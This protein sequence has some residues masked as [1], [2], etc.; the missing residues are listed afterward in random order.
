MSKRM[1]EAARNYSIAELEMCGSFVH[2]LKKVDFDVIVDN[3]AI[4]HIMKSKAEPTTTRIKRLLEL[5]ST[6]SF[7][8]YYI[9]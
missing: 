8:L 5:L 4:R 3:L 2:L 7:N 1:P 6:Y 9:K